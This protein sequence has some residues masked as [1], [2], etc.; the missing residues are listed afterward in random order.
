MKT[1]K[2]TNKDMQCR[3]KQYEIG[4]KEVEHNGIMC[5]YRGFHSCE[6]PFDVLRYYPPKSGNRFF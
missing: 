2:G 4:R 1:Y 3:E 5:R 6:A